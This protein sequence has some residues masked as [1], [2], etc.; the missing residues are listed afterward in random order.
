MDFLVFILRERSNFFRRA[1]GPKVL[2]G[3]GLTRGSTSHSQKVSA[4]KSVFKFFR[5]GGVYI[6][7]GDVVL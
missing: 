4:A 5:T 2:R 6:L 1:A 7:R 3:G